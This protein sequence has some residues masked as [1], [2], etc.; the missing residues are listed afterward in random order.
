MNNAKT[1]HKP[2][3][4]QLVL[5][6]LAALLL[7]SGSGLLLSMG[8]LQLVET[9]INSPYATQSFMLAAG[10]LLGG[11]LMLPSAWH[12][13]RRL[14][15][16]APASAMAPELAEQPEAASQTLPRAED[17]GEAGSAA[18][19]ARILISKQR[20]RRTTGLMLLTLGLV[21]GVPLALLAG[22]WITRENIL[23][24]L[25]LP[26]LNLL[27]I[28]LPI[29]WLVMTGKRGLAAGSAQRQWGIF[30]S[31]LALGPLIILGIELLVLLGISL[32]GLIVI[33]RDPALMR[34]FSFLINRL[35]HAQPDQE[36]L[37]RILT[38][39]LEQPVVLVGIFGFA[40]V[41]V[42]LIEEALK[43]FGLWLMAGCRLTPAE[44]FV[45]GLISGAGFALFENLFSTS[46]GGET[47]ALLASS[48]ITT[49]MLHMLASGLVGW[50]LAHAWGRGRYFRLAFAY[51]LAV[52]LHGVWNSL[53][54][55]S[56]IV[57]YLDSPALETLNPESLDG[58]IVI[59]LGMLAFF[60]FILYLGFNR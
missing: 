48:R 27:V 21:A 51:A 5:S 32:V 17:D 44:G 8:I 34:E 59:G 30:A 10:L 41:L 50:G 12:A 55:A 42:P 54:I 35:T 11:G 25:L 57:P 40:A 52:M 22:D 26:G 49:A 45:G 3:L 43:P 1:L 13:W 16:H 53:G 18:H 46:A 60:N 7:V 58:L 24:W 6:L 23:P 33:M 31:G 9:G 39:M 37:L 56:F 28:G 14:R 20:L 47:W 36:A 15:P 19:P 29:L 2:S 4:L 38:P